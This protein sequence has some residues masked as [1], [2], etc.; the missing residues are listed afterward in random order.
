MAIFDVMV[1]DD[2]GDLFAAKILAKV[3][4]CLPK[5]AAT[6]LRYFTRSAAPKKCHLKTA[7]F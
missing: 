2:L 4:R 3:R 6:T 5:I 1:I 7:E